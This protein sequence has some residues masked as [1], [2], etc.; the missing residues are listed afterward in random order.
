MQTSVGKDSPLPLYYQLKTHILESISAGEYA[1]GQMLPSERELQERFGVS[2][3]TVR[4]A[5]AE[6]VNEGVLER[7]QGIGTIVAPKRIA[8]QLL[9]LTSFTEDMRG[10][11]HAA[12][13]QTLTASCVA[14]PPNVRERLM[15]APGES[16]WEVY[17]L[18]LADGEPIGLQ[19]LYVPAWLGLD[20]Q[21]FLQMTSYYRLLESK[22]GVTVQWGHELLNART[23][24][25]R[26]A[27]L[28]QTKTGS[29]LINVE[30]VSYDQQERPVEHVFFVY[31]A[32]RYV[33][34]LT[35]YR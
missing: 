13:S 8:P 25:A 4:Q 28:L 11:G 2:R 16:V 34:D 9:R 31:R 35:L 23:A 30:R 7:R 5:L 12:G 20:E 18:R 19:Q 1:P 3:A 21:D 15:L 17:R 26:E 29:A 6:L 14:P 33:Y 22:S 10:R 27:R 32:D 24:T